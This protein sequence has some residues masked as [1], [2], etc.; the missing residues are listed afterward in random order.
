MSNSDA[1]LTIKNLKPTREDLLWLGG[2]L[3]AAA[4]VVILAVLNWSGVTA[5]NRH[6][7]KLQRGRLEV[8]QLLSA[9]KDAETGQRGF[10]L[11]GNETYLAPYSS[12]RSKV[13]QLFQELR[14]DVNED[15]QLASDLGRLQAEVTAKISE[16]E[17]TISLRRA[18]GFEAALG[19]VETDR[20]LHYMDEIR[21]ITQRMLAHQG[22]LMTESYSAVERKSLDSLIVTTL[23][24]FALLL[25]IG[26]INL[27]FK[28]E[29][30]RAIAAS[31]AKSSFLA[32]MSHELRTPLNA[33]IGYS[34]MVQEDLSVELNPDAIAADL[35]KIQAAGKHLLELINAVLDLSK[36]E[37]GK[38]DLYL[39]TF[40]IHGLAEEVVKYSTALG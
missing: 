16:L 8:F 17:D 4:I 18:D 12:A 7:Q 33:I 21:E 28:R 5:A 26:F 3:L 22:A 20:G 38:M 15:P 1:L 25:I 9:M 30:D 35:Q 36:I 27:N 23:A 37:A 11:T 40:A 10:L 39:E 24:S 32:N 31:H 2:A 6:Y 14:S 34:E 29:K 13:P 19:V